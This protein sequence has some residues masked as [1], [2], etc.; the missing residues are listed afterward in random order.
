MPGVRYGLIA[1]EV[2][3]VDTTLVGYDDEGRPNSVRY[4]SIVPLLI[5]AV[6]EIAGISGTFEANLLTSLGSASNGIQDLFAKSLH[7]ENARF[8]NLTVTGHTVL[9]DEVCV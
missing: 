6:K 9:G 7:A 5:D 2:D 1:E 8:E 4:T 3:A